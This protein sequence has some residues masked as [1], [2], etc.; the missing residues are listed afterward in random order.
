MTSPA[1]ANDPRIDSQIALLRHT[2]ASLAYRAAKAFRGAPPEFAAFKAS[3]RTRTPG[4]IL[5]HL[6]D[7][8]DW[9]LTQCEGKVAW[10]D[11]PALDWHAGSARFFAALDKFD[12]YLASGAPVGVSPAVL[13]QGAIADAHGHVGQINMLRGIAG[14]PIR[15]EDHSRAAVV[16]GRVGAEQTP[17]EQEF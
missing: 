15:A 3:P 13:F 16:A 11:S 14:C 8:F 2:L 6:G 4:E 17:P 1:A 9:A 5:A 7:L 10:H 12:K